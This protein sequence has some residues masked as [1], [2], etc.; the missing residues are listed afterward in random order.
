MSGNSAEETATNMR[1]RNNMRKAFFEFSI[2]QAGAW[3]DFARLSFCAVFGINNPVSAALIDAR[4]V[5]AGGDRGVR[6]FML[7]AGTDHR[8]AVIARVYSRS[9]LLTP[10]S[11]FLNSAFGI[12]WP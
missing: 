6:E 10:S 12:V 7:I 11:L 4:T 3:F 5:A 8:N 1:K 9:L 2:C